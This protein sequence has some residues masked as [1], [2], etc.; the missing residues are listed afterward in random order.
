[1]QHFLALDQGT[2]SSRAI[3]FS[4]DGRP[5]A[6]AQ[7]EFRQIYPQPGWVEHDPFDILGTQL[8][9]A[10]EA[11][12][13][14]V[15]EV[16]AIGV[17]NQRE[18]TLLWDKTT[19]QPLYNAIV[20]QD[21][22]TAGHCDDLKAQ[23][24]EP[25]FRQKTGLLLD[26]YFSGTK[27][28]WLLAHIP[29]A[30]DRAMRGELA[31]GTV[32]SWLIYNL[33]QGK[34]HATDTTNACRTLLFNIHTNTWDDELLNI[35][36][37]PHSLLPEIKASSDDYGIATA[38]G[39]L[40]ISGVAG[41]QHAALFGQACLETGMAK[42][43]YGTGCFML[44]NTG[45]TAVPSQSGLLSTTAWRLEHTTY[46]LE[47][48]V[49]IAGAV[50]QWLRDGLGIIQ[51][52]SEVENLAAMVKD[53]AGVYVVPAFVGL[54]A[55]YWDAYARGTIVGLTRGVGKAEIARA[56]L[57]SVA[58][59][60]RDV[61]EAMSKDSGIALS[62]LRVDG[63]A[64]QNNLLMQFQADIL[65]VPV[66]RPK[67]TETTAWGAA[68]LAALRHGVDASQLGQ[69]WSLERRFEPTMSQAERDARYVGWQ[70]AVRATRAFSSD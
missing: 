33:T 47:G 56:A 59:Q 55:P 43:T 64:T 7:K 1:M 21:R 26:P 23:G 63:G 28:A 35:L 49:F 3:V 37:I 34:V 11:L 42:N 58:F 52:A 19:G 5:V 36:G 53:S 69:Q 41:D 17:T 30:R 46:A 9:T 25:V 50:V 39:N 62:E 13:G 65:G 70:R 31:F 32:D 48:S 18:T 15:G 29:G 40:P 45:T 2:T 38:L 10:R 27:L 24:L 54:G 22:R 12:S 66:V 14:I 44:L 61:L 67:V 57:E 51:N 60:T 8:Q 6:S 16:V 68:S 20:W 4:H